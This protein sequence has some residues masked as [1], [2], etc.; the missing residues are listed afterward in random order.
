MFL[1]I[2][3]FVPDRP[4]SGNQSNDISTAATEGKTENSTSPSPEEN[5]NDS[6]IKQIE[7]LTKKCQ[8]LDVGSCII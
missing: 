7:E 8:E 1:Y 2:S 4:A 3:R 6:H 5:K